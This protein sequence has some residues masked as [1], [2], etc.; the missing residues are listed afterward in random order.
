MDNLKQL[1]ESVTAR[2]GYTSAIGTTVRH[3]EKGRV[4][5]AL[6]RRPELLQFSGFFHGGVIAGLADHA[7]GAAVTTAL[8]EDRFVVTVDMHVNFLSPARGDCII[9][10][11]T[12]IQMGSTICVA[13]VTVEAAQDEERRTCAFAVVTLRVIDRPGSL[14]T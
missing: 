6:S 12:A 9:A 4:E 10:N 3:V 7:A 14:P 2:P 8:P 5:L 13:K 1:V 11:A